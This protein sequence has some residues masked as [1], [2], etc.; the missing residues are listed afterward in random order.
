MRYKWI[1]LYNYAGIY[2]GMGLTQIKIDFTR[3]RTNKIIIRGNNGSGKSTLMDAINP[4]PDTNDKFIPGVEARKNICLCDNGIDY[5]IRYIHPVTNSG[6]GT[7]KGYISKTMDGNLVELNPNGN[8]SSCRDILYSE[9]NLDSNYLSLSQLTSENRGLVD[10]KPAERK[11]LINSI[12]SSLE[13]YN[14]IHKNLTK[15]S[16][17]YKS[18]VTS[19]TAKIDYIGNPVALNTKLQNI[20]NRLVSLEQEKNTTIEAIAAVKIKISDF[21]AILRDNNYDEIVKEIKSLE[22]EIRS[23]KAALEKK[24]QANNISDVA[25]LREHQATLLNTIASLEADIAILKGQIPG[26]LAQREAEFKEL[27]NKQEK[28]NSLQSDYN[29][30]DI[31]SAMES[32][33]SV[34]KTHE[35]VFNRMGLLNITL[36]TQ[37]E[38]DTAM[39]ALEYLRTSANALT[40]SYDLSL[41]AKVVNDRNTVLAM[42]RMVPEKKK[43]LEE[44]KE[45]RSKLEKDFAVYQSKRQIADELRNR[46]ENCSID[47]C[48]YIKSAV[49]ADRDYPLQRM[50]TISDEISRD[51]DEIENIARFLDEASWLSEILTY[52]N[53]IER[54]LESKIKFIMKLPIR[55]DFKETFMQRVVNL[56]PF[57]DI[58]ALYKF[59]D[60][61]NM[62]EEYKV[63]KEQLKT[64]EMEYR[65]YES[66]NKI[67][68]SIISDITSLTTKTNELASAIDKCNDT[69]Q[70]KEQKLI[71]LKKTKDEIENML[72]IVENTYVPAQMKQ[73]ELIS[74]RNSLDGYTSELNRLQDELS[75]LNTNMVAVNNDSKALTD[76]RDA[77][78]HSLIL[79]GDY[80]RELKEYSDKY[81]KIE[82]I[83]YYSSSSTGIQTIFM[84]LYM[85]NIIR[86]ANELLSLLFDGEFA[87]QPFVINESEFRIPCLGSGLLHD[88][89]SSMSTAQ[90]SMI[91][92]ILS[93]SILNQSATRYNIIRLDELDGGLDTSNRGYF[94]TLLDRLMGMLRC[95]QAFIISHNNELDSSAADIIVLKNSSHETYTG[96]IIWQF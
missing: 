86:T 25:K 85:N 32:A 14:A 3:C 31:K 38:F 89:I 45:L 50:V 78:K 68:E 16:S 49:E 65:L 48:P 33:K 91:S 2:N 84:S 28:L 94:I 75:K 93:F 55:R 53:A 24:M 19:L 71:D 29:Y 12:I 57:S 26:L 96:N 23:T 80:Q 5:I 6:R 40:S 18:L 74:T 56:D 30:L 77:I 66:K 17:T 42:I 61:G 20:E 43:D 35:G 15:K 90:K 9:F 36:I 70:I 67:I 46:P 37:S 41:I 76:E 22:V 10:S 64:Y 83:R 79:L 52:V 44:Y 47:T 81:T 58:D 13:T 8:I 72:S 59:V 88:D 39:D 21:L 63:A 95:E 92:M 27:Q 54:E 60:C 69:V 7:T 62:I 1:E 73:Q 87:L 51:S 82:K 4:N 11:K 34:V